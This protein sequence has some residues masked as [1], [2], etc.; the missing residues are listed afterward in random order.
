MDVKDCALCHVLAAE[1]EKANGKRYLT[2]G[3]SFSQT[4]ATQTVAK[5]FPEQ[6]HR[7]PPASSE[8]EHYDYSSARLVQPGHIVPPVPRLTLFARTELSKT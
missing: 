4:K 7:L 5:L 1:T 8:A 2:V 3:S 6:A